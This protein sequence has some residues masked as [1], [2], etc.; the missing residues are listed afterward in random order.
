MSVLQF[1]SPPLPGYIRSGYS[2]AGPGRKHPERIAI[3]EFDLLVVRQGCLYVGEEERRYAVSEGHALILRP[4]L[5]HYPTEGT[6]EQTA[7]YWLHFDTEGSWRALGENVNEGEDVNEGEV[8]GED[9]GEN[10][11]ED[12][13]ENKG[14]NPA[15]ARQAK[16]RIQPFAIRLPQFTRLAEPGRMYELL[17]RLTRLESNSHLDDVRWR[18]QRLFQEVL[19]LL[20]DSLAARGP[21]PG[22]EVADR[23]ASYLRLHY[24]EPLTAA[25]LGEALRFH[26]VY[27]A[28]CMRRR[29]GC[30][31]MEYLLRYRLEQAK[32]L[33]LQTDLPILQIA[34]ETGF[35]QAAY[36][37]SC[38]RAREGLTPRAYRHVF[39][40]RR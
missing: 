14:A 27:V 16:P 36:F 13:G 20:A 38:F 25:R 10:E 5:H 35:Q 32:R 31:P 19:P 39:H 8:G 9:Q 40:G 7:S 6:R 29:F 1:D 2:L 4:D 37:T 22:E 33:L 26:P 15:E 11:G 12:Q 23:A 28:R 24:A 21:K 30:A 17:D 34:R 18:Q 3:G